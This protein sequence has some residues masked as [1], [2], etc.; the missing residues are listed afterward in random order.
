MNSH[1]LVY[2]D[3]INSNALVAL[4]TSNDSEHTVFTNNIRYNSNALEYRFR[5][6]SN[7]INALVGIEST[8]MNITTDTAINNIRLIK[9]G[10]SIAS[11]KTLTINTPLQ[12]SG[13]M[14][15]ADATAAL[16]LNGD[17]TLAS[18][19]QFTS[20]ATINGNGKMLHLGGTFNPGNDVTIVG[21]LIIDGNGNDVYF[22]STNQLI[23]DSATTVTLQNMN[24]HL[25]G[26][27]PISITGTSHITLR[28]VNIK[29]E[30]NV[31]LASGYLHIN[32][33][34]VV[35]GEGYM[36]TYSST[37]PL[38]IHDN[39]LLHFGVGTEFTFNPGGSVP[40]TVG[41]RDLLRTENRTAL[42]AFNSA[43][44]TVPTAGVNFVNGTIVFENNVTLNNKDA[45]NNYNTNP[46]YAITIDSTNSNIYVLAGARVEVNGY[47]DILGS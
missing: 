41:Q 31:T 33:G 17:L 36:L 43:V 10:F 6:N 22:D 39:S 42:L 28:N 7:T 4:K 27:S 25:T 20:A 47:V 40:H 3:R 14:A 18:D 23:L 15:F 24:V 9:N 44:F 16:T 19:A 11:G 8:T 38:I 29:L 5:T 32:E 2:G 12:V 46:A 37:N 30:N 45:S 35:T 21:G 34:V 13:N 26:N 1:A